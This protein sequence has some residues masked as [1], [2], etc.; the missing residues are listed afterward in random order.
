ML[1]KLSMIAMS[2]VFLAGCEEKKKEEAP[3]PAAPAAAPA[4]APPS[5]GAAP[6]AAP[7]AGAPAAP[8]A[9]AAAAAPAGGKGDVKGTVSL[10]GKGPEMTDLK[11]ATDP[12]CGKTKMKDEEVVAKGGKLAN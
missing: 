2:V 8:G 12:F 1:R 6:A 9:P 7:A 5:G 3:A 4:A 10:T 11:R